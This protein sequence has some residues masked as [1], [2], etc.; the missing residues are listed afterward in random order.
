MKIV[1]TDGYTVNPGDTSWDSIAALG[2]LTIH[3]RTAPGEL[4]ERCKEAAII[5][6][7]KVVINKEA[8]NQLPG[9]KMIGVL[10][11]GYNVVDVKAAREKNIA[12]CNVPAYGTDSVA[13]HTFALL[14][15]L[16]NRI[17]IHS[18]S[19]ANGEWAS[20][21]D[22]SYSKTPLIELAGKTMGIVGFGNIGQQTARIA[23]ALGMKV[24][25]NGPNKKET[26]LGTFVDLQTLFR[27][28]DFISLHCPLTADNKEF[29]NKTL[30]AKMKKST[31][32]INTARG[33]L[34]QE[35]DLADALNNH[36]IAGAALDVLSTEPPA[37]G[38]PL[39]TAK[40]CIITPHNAWMTKEARERVLAI[41]AKN[42]QAFIGGKPV[43]VVN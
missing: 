7:N 15:E 33:L 3:D 38:N 14:L 37:A 4:I 13:Q 29:V 18:T 26:T 24:I 25:Y 2:S 34:I 39:L 11:T 31:F 20:A 10:A 35:Q 5:L 21:I 36:I 30:L 43:N 41:T 32:I 40:N 23:Q 19:V 8:L 12:V 27:E 1:V 6:T 28:S 42:I 16:T 22:W 17:G 9:L